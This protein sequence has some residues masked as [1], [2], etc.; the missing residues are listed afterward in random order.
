M[1]D[2]FQFPNNWKFI[3]KSTIVPDD[4]ETKKF[5]NKWN[6][7]NKKNNNWTKLENQIT[8]KNGVL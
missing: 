1:K 2:L 8:A 4:K 6:L 3:N 5:G 7:N